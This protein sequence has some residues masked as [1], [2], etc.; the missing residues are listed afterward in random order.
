MGFI[1]F[2]DNDE[3]VCMPKS[4]AP[5]YIRF[6]AAFIMH[7]QLEPQIRRALSMM[8]YVMNHPSEFDKPL[9][10]FTC[11]SLSALIT[12]F[13]EIL[14]IGYIS[15][16]TDS[17]KIISVAAAMAAV[18]KVATLYGSSL[19]SFVKIKAAVKPI[20]IKVYRQVRE[21][22]L[23]NDSKCILCFTRACYAFQRIVYSTFI[24]YYIPFFV[25]NLPFMMRSDLC[26]SYY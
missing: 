20:H 23:K 10:A 4:F 19:P 9:F 18:S 21:E 22:E 24:F 6:G 17:I 5:F 14:S 12:E 7:L 16:L 15:T 11:G 1:I 25:I 2:H 8:K 26:K 3:N 13:T